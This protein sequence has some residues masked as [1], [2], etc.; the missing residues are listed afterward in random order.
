MFDDRFLNFEC[1]CEYQKHSYD[2]ENINSFYL[3]LTSLSHNLN[4]TWPS[5]QSTSCLTLKT[6]P[7]ESYFPHLT[8]HRLTLLS[9]FP[10]HN[11]LS[12]YIPLT[13]SQLSLAS[14]FPHLTSPCLTS[15]HFISF[16]LTQENLSTQE[17]VKL[18]FLLFMIEQKKSYQILFT[19]TK[20]IVPSQSYHIF[21]S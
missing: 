10:S 18:S 15:L 4:S 13:S 19:E 11:F 17:N 2:A 9:G 5:T 1:M 7:L 3:P 14:F 12:T 20:N 21:K 6:F 16:S 8:F